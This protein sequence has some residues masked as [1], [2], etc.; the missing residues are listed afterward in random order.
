MLDRDHNKIWITPN[1][2]NEIG[3]ST[4]RDI[5]LNVKKVEV[6]YLEK[7]DVTPS[8]PIDNNASF[9]Y[10]SRDGKEFSIL[11]DKELDEAMKVVGDILPNH[12]DFGT[13]NFAQ[14]IVYRQGTCFDAHK[15][16]ADNNDYATAIFT[17]N[18]DYLGGKFTVEPGITIDRCQGTMVAFNNSTEVWHQVEPVYQGERWVFAVWFGRE[19]V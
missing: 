15:D 4:L 2:L 16:E 7:N 18:D 17:L 10:D 13:V 6:E 14:V 12:I 9:R 19:N 5:H 3:C 8:P 11:K 1:V